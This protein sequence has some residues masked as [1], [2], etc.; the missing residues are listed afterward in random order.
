[1]LVLVS[2]YC[3]QVTNHL[4]V[5]QTEML[6]LFIQGKN[7]G[8]IF[9]P[10]RNVLQYATSSIFANIKSES[11]L[12]P[13]SNMST[14]I[15]AWHMRIEHINMAGK[16]NRNLFRRGICH[17]SHILSLSDQLSP[18]LPVTLSAR[19]ATVILKYSELVFTAKVQ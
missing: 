12:N 6:L 11:E 5:I 3:I 17:K 7:I 16:G 1:M 2:Q 4:Q 8:L 15:I 9:S 19:D 18:W 14:R 13:T 10:G